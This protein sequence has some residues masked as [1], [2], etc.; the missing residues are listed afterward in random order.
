MRQEYGIYGHN[1]VIAD[2]MSAFVHE[3]SGP[4][5]DNLS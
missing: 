3:F 1:G 4:A 2:A 5:P